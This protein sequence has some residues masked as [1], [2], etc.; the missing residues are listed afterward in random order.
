MI[1]NKF[2]LNYNLKIAL[3]VNYCVVNYFIA[4][5]II[6]SLAI[7]FRYKHAQIHKR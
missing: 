5:L 6:A 2:V 4:L 3:I 7:S 1:D